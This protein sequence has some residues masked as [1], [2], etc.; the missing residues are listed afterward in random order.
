MTT[1]ID[2]G[3]NIAQIHEKAMDGSRAVVWA[4]DG[5]DWVCPGTGNEH[6]PALA[7]HS[8]VLALDA[9]ARIL[10][11]QE[12][13]ADTLDAVADVVRLSGRTI[14]DAERPR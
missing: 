10:S 7:I 1:C 4:S 14:D 5:G 12:W 13:S 9:I 2:C 6:E 11:G 3:R 8:P